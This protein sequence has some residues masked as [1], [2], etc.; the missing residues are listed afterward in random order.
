[1]LL[2]FVHNASDV[3]II[4][5]TMFLYSFA[6]NFISSAQSAFLTDVAHRRTTGRRQRI[7]AHGS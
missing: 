4:Y 1:M 3:W 7:L 2:L 5:V 6:G